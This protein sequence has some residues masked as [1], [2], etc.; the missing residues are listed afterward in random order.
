MKALDASRANICCGRDSVGVW[1]ST[2][3][4]CVPQRPRENFE[5]RHPFKPITI[6][7]WSAQR[8]RIFR[9]MPAESTKKKPAFAERVVR[10]VCFALSFRQRCWRVFSD[11]SAHSNDA[12]GDRIRHR[13]G[14]L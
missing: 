1:P 10:I 7:P 8:V 13:V 12:A 14:K 4:T 3:M 9:L 11:M 5:L 6:K 2:P